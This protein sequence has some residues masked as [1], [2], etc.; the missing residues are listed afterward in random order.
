MISITGQER[1]HSGLQRRQVVLVLESRQLKDGHEIR[2]DE[3]VKEPTIE[4]S[5]ACDEPKGVSEIVLDEFFTTP[6]RR[7]D[8][9]LALLKC[10]V[11]M[12]AQQPRRFV[13]LTWPWNSSTLPTLIPS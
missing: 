7:Y 3:S 13:S 11:S 4:T 6:D 12:Y 5:R 8:D 1:E 2:I 9:D 10:I